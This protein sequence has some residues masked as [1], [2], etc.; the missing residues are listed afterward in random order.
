MSLI[1]FSAS[2]WIDEFWWFDFVYFLGLEV[3]PL[4]LM[5]LTLKNE[6]KAHLETRDADAVQ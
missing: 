2:P 4:I 3:T 6:K 5:L 1:T